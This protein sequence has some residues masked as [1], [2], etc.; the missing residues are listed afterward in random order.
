MT[1]REVI[2]LIEKGIFD[3]VKV[4]LE[5][6]YGHFV[7]TDNIK[8]ETLKKY[9]HTHVNLNYTKEMKA[10]AISKGNVNFIKDYTFVK[11]L[12]EE[13][14]LKI[15]SQF[16][17]AMNSVR[18]EITFLEH[19][20]MTREIARTAIKRDWCYHSYACIKDYV[21]DEIKQYVFDKYLKMNIAYFIGLSFQMTDD[22]WKRLMTPKY[23]SSASDYIEYSKKDKSYKIKEHGYTV[24]DFYVKYIITNNCYTYYNFAIE[25]KFLV[26]FVK[27]WYEKYKEVLAYSGSEWSDGGVEKK[28]NLARFKQVINVSKYRLDMLDK[29][30]FVIS[31][32]KKPKKSEMKLIIEKDPHNLKLIKNP[33]KEICMM[34]LTIDKTVF[35][36]IP[37]LKV[38]KEM[39]DLAGVEEP[40]LF[41]E[42]Y[43][44]VNSTMCVCDYSY[45]DYVNVKKGSDMKTFMNTQFRVCFGDIDDGIVYNTCKHFSY[46][47]ITKEAFDML[48]ELELDQVISGSWLF[49]YKGKEFEDHEIKL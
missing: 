25:G 34:A 6:E 41:P 20:N 43:Y 47:P 16:T 29:Y 33:S 22:M 4:K 14:V 46:K 45:V 36:H 5:N 24:P 13:E 40:D 7:L 32:L 10:Y 35:E 8:W 27:D 1:E 39:A 42:E 38:T 31:Y 9:P 30:P 37:E 18:S 44:L 3:P 48:R 19:V 12:S 49:Y 28:Q 23:A 15:V 17:G 2:T 26:Y 21:D 11:S